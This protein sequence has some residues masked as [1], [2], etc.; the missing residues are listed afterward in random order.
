MLSRLVLLFVLTPLAELALLVYVGTV[1]GVLYT[2]VIVVATG[3]L[4][5]VLARKQGLATL[6]RIRSSISHRNIPSDEL[7]NG[8]LILA[9]GLLLLTPGLITDVV[10]FAL[11]IPQTRRLVGAWLRKIVWRR[12]QKTEVYYWEVR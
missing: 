8:A 6:A 11:L 2:V 4:G 1:V 7:F 10:G 12:I 9:G 5:A 3:F